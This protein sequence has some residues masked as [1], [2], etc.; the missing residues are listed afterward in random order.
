MFTSKEIL[1]MALKIEKNGETVYRQ[2]VKGLTNPEMIQRLTWM[3]DE[4]ARHAEWFMKMK[5]ELDTHKDRMS[6]DEMN[7]D[8]LNDIIGKQS[9][10]CRTSISPMWAV[11]AASWTFLSNLKKTVFYSMNCCGPLSRTGRFFKASIGL[12]QK[13]TS[14]LK[15]SRK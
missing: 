15:H 6:V 9:F 13:N 2:A 11:S 1:D 7:R 4:E 10:P 3:A 5:S 14:T 12:S 8:I